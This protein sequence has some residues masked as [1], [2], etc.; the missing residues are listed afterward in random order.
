[1]KNFDKIVTYDTI[2][3]F[4]TAIGF[5]KH[6]DTE[7]TISR[8]EGYHGDEPMKSP[9]F[10]TNYFTFLLI[11]DGEGSY[12]ID[13]LFFDLN[14]VAFYFT[15]PGHLKS[16]EITKPWKG[17][18]LSVT[19]NFIK[20]YFVGDLYKEF[21]FL[22]SETSPPIKAVDEIK[23]NLYY[24]FES[25]LKEYEG[26]SPFK[27][28]IITNLI[29]AFLFKVKEILELVPAL[30]GKQFSY[31]PLVIKFYKFLDEHFRAVVSGKQK[32][33]FNLN[34]IADKLFVNPDYLGSVVKKETGKSVTKWIT[35]KII[36][37]AQSMLSNTNLTVAEIGY[38][39]TFEDPTNFTKYFKK[40]TGFTPK[41]YREK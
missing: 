35:E 29:I 39:L 5:P 11:T 21:P 18:I 7:F 4:L 40:N 33:L 28:Q 23:V 6:Q 37:E 30:Q 17:F 8:L 13:G 38:R 22:I 24:R 16:F 31:S 32:T 9:N 20:K 27:Y 15:N 1:M 14:P 34:Q 36:A 25:I 19:E 2:S 26:I 3:Q 10:R 12:T 41:E